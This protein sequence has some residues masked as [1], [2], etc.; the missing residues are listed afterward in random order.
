MKFRFIWVVKFP[1]SV[2]V[3][4]RIRKYNIEWPYINHV[5]HIYFMY[6][7]ML[8]YVLGFLIVHLHVRIESIMD[9]YVYGFVCIFVCK[10]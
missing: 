1:N 4:E 3:L 6:R 2:N 9:N 5:V 10:P 8:S 7:P